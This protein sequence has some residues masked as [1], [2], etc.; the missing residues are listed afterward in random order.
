[1]KFDACLNQND[2]W[3][4]AKDERFTTHT[5]I[6]DLGNRKSEEAKNLQLQFDAFHQQ[7]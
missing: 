1:M 7:T 5:G 4:Y 2:N 3:L 6:A